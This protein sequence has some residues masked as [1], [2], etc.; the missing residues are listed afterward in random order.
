MVQLPP[1][2]KIEDM[3]MIAGLG[4]WCG[5]ELYYTFE[6]VTGRLL[7]LDVLVCVWRR[8]AF[9]IRG[10]E[11]R[12]VEAPDLGSPFENRQKL[13]GL[14][15]RI[16]PFDEFEIEGESFR[17]DVWDDGARIPHWIV[18]EEVG[19]SGRCSP[20]HGCVGCGSRSSLA[21]CRA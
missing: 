6:S 13:Q 19:F 9:G 8:E 16:A 4:S 5:L 11:R 12:V 20:V 7:G 10:A 1:E 17:G 15:Q 2:L 18:Y 3:F 21:D 14:L